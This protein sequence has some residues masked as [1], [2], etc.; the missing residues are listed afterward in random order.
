VSPGKAEPEHIAISKSKGV[1]IDWRDGHRSEYTVAW[2]RDECPCASCTGAHGT[3][4]QRTSY[5]APPK[6]LFPMFKPALR[7]DRIEEVGHYAVRIYWNDGHSAGIYS[8]DHLRA[9]CPCAEC[10]DMRR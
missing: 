1:K 7:M 3:E 5:S 8:F 10:R 6:D 2:L 4:P 9:I